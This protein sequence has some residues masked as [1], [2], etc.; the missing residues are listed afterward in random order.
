MSKL[1]KLAIIIWSSLVKNFNLRIF[2]KKLWK[3]RFYKKLL[4]KFLRWNKALL[5]YSILLVMSNKQPCYNIGLVGSVS[6][7][8]SQTVKA[9][10]GVETFTHSKE[11]KLG[12]TMRI[13]YANCCIYKCTKCPEPQCY[14]SSGSRTTLSQCVHCRSPLDLVEYFS[15]IDCPGHESLMSTMLSGATIMDYAILLIDGSQKTF[16]SQTL[17]H[18]AAI[19]LM[20]IK[21]IIILQ[22]KL[23]LVDGNKA[24]EQYDAIQQLIKGTCA[25]SA[26]IIPFS[27]QK[28]YNL[29]VLCEFIVKYFGKVEREISTPKMNIIRSF[30]V[31]KPGSDIPL[32]TGGVLG[33]SLLKGEFKVGDIIE[34]RP[35]I[36]KQTSNGKTWDQS[37]QFNLPVKGQG[38]TESKPLLA[39]IIS[40]KSDSDAIEIA[41]PGGLIGLCTNLDPSLT[42]SDKMVGQVVGL[43]GFMPDVYTECVAKCHFLERLNMETKLVPRKGDVVLLNISSKPITATILR[44]N[45]SLYKFELKYPCCMVPGEKFS[46]SAKIGNSWKLVGLCVLLDK[47]N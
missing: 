44:N 24:Q 14:Q 27:A 25:E 15:F 7:G 39:K 2:G 6:H 20:Q 41:R 5:I 47:N 21:K 40:M 22:N 36:I 3:K 19:E 13:G 38:K 17:E 26:P 43:P 35:G 11:K 10:T 12:I 31:N 34:I 45:K 9:L 37:S 33:G 28:K 30:D 4:K 16:S 32:I 1:K 18:L 46:M 42:K 23:D 8:K 29:D